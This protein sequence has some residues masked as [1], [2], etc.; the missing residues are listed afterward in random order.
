MGWFGWLRTS[1]KGTPAVSTATAAWTVGG[2]EYTPGVPYM[3]P[4]DMA[5]VN[6]L[7][8]QHFMLRQALQGNYAAPLATPQ[9]ILDVGTGTGRW[10]REMAALF[11]NANVI[12]LDVMVPTIDDVAEEGTGPDLRPPNYTF[13]A[14]N[15]LEGLPFADASFDFVHQRFLVAAMPGDRW[16]QAIHELVRVTV[17][18]GW[19]ELVEASIWFDNAGPASSAVSSWF[20]AASK[21]R[22]IDLS[23]TD[24]LPPLLEAAGLARVEQRVVKIP[25]GEW[26]GRLGK[27]AGANI[28]SGTA[29]IKPLVANGKDVTPEVWEQTMIAWNEELHTQQAS[30]VCYILYGQRPA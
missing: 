22:G 8:F 14:A 1:R 19:V 11:P 23:M 17:P 16:Q 9:S 5:E 10:A 28:A 18:G 3:L 29:A 4:T 13:V 25:V 24:N 30:M 12:G 7:D 26:G 20:L 2:R 6:R 15:L 27:M 21:R